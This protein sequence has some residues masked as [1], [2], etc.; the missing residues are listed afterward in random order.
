MKE[1]Y[2]DKYLLPK[3]NQFKNQKISAA[4]FVQFAGSVGIVSCPGGPI[5]RTVVGRKDSSTPAPDGL[6]PQAFGPGSDYQ[7]LIDL[8]E[9]KTFSPR[10][11]AALMGA[12]SVSRSFAQRQMPPGSSQDSTPTEWDVKYYIQTQSQPSSLPQGVHSFD[13]DVNLSNATTEA[14]R[15]FREF[16]GDAERWKAEFAAAMAKLSVLGISADEV[17]GFVDCTELLR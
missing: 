11:L 4:D 13:S 3:Y 12:H 2:R 6:L 15:A 10:E 9:S 14:G 1:N 8:W 17:E 7:S 5:V 16:A